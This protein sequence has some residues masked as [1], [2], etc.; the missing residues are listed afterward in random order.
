MLHTENKEKGTADFLLQTVQA[1]KHWRN[2]FK[3]LKE[4]KIINLE[5]YTN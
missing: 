2:I 1:R 4:K 5:F 3:V